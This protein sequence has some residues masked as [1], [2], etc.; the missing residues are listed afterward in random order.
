[1]PDP[2]PT[3]LTVDEHERPAPRAP[4]GQPRLDMDPA[5]EQ[6]DLVLADGPGRLGPLERWMRDGQGD[7]FVPHGRQVPPMSK[8]SPVAGLGAK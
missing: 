3:Q 1:M 7:G 2:R 6:V 5:L 4:F 8:T